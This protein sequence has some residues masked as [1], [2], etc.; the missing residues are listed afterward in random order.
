MTDEVVIRVETLG[1]KHRIRHSQT[2][3]FESTVEWVVYAILNCSGRIY[4]GQTGQL[5]RRLNEHNAGLVRS[6]KADGPWRL[7]AIEKCGTQS[8]ARWLEFQ[9]KRSR[10]KRTTWLQQRSIEANER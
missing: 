8:E 7:L 3:K 5:E 9:L 2:R 1:K 10:G 4:I 6:T